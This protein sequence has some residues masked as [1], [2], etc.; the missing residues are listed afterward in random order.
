MGT[1]KRLVLNYGLAILAVVLAVWI[2]Y[3]LTPMLGTRLPFITLFGAVGVAVWAWPVNDRECV[4]RCR[5]LGVDGI[6][7]DDVAALADI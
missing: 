7:G 4:A 1:T 2:R 6:M 3:L 5:A